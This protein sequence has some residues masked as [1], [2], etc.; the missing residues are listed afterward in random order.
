MQIDE[1]LIDEEFK[2]LCPG[3]TDD[4][5]N[6]LRQN[7]L[8]DG[9][10]HDPI[11]VWKSNDGVILVD[12]HNRL[13]IWLNLTVEQRARIAPPAINAVEFKNRPMVNNWI[14]CQQ[15]GRRNLDLKQKA[16]LVGRWYHESKKEPHRPA[17][18]KGDHNEHLNKTADRISEKSGQSPAQVRRDAKFT[19]AVDTL[20]ANVGPEVKTE[21]LQTK[22]V[23]KKKVMEIAELP[24]NRQQAEYERAMGR[25]EPAGGLNFNPEEWGGMEPV[26]DPVIPVDTVTEFHLKEM[27]A[28][29]RE[30]QKHL[31]AVKKAI[32]K[33]SEGPGGAWCGPNQMTDIMSCYNNL[34]STINHRKPVAI[35]GHCNGKKCDRCYQTGALNKDLADTLKEG[36]EATE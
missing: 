17:K 30:V 32:E 20:A 14:I 9:A 6:Q 25:G 18:K 4:E 16:Y 7:I 10:F 15:L 1:I 31:T 35:C 8:D 2:N 21:I 33:L 36:R 22:E 29:W 23:S 5:L 11:T 24:A 19:E 34:K 26:A 12:G 13:D 3:L 27:Q 28:P